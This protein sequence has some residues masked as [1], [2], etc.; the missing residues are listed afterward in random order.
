MGKTDS[1]DLARKTLFAILAVSVPISTSIASGTVFALL[2][3]CLAD[4][5]YRHQIKQVFTSKM[6]LAWIGLCVLYGVGALYSTAEP[7]KIWWTFKNICRVIWLPCWIPFFYDAKNRD[8]T[9]N[10]F[11]AT[12]L[13]ILFMIALKNIGLPIYDKHGARAFTKDTIYTGYFISLSVIVSLYQLSYQLRAEKERNY[14]QFLYIVCIIAGSVYMLS[15]NHSRTGFIVFFA[16]LVSFFFQYKSFFYRYVKQ[17]FAVALVIGGLTL[18]LPYN[19]LNC[20][21]QAKSQYIEYQQLQ[22]SHEK[23]VRLRTSIGERSYFLKYGWELF[24]E[25][26]VFGWGTGGE[27]T[28]LNKRLDDLGLMSVSDP[29]NQYLAIMLALGSVGLVYLLFCLFVTYRMSFYLFAKEASLARVVLLGFVIGCLA[30]SWLVSFTST[31]L[32]ILFISLCFGAQKEKAAL[33]FNIGKKERTIKNA[34]A[35]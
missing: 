16:M 27:K 24:L 29:H 19:H 15:F 30:N 34:V 17:I 32:F 8:R 1:F 25:K 35:I 2:F 28:H 11:I 4:A 9:L 6:I 10:I 31:H 14:L 5:Q 3:V 26:P 23:P 7:E 20:W 12:V 21:K 22:K 33:Y 18:L 13:F